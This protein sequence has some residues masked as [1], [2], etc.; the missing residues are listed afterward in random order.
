MLY[1]GFD[2]NYLQE[3]SFFFNFCYFIFLPQNYQQINKTHKRQQN[4]LMF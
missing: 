2:E 3:I 4:I 1:I